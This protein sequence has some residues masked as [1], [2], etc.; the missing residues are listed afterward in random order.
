MLLS[1][2]VLRLSSFGQ[3]AKGEASSRPRLTSLHK[4]LLIPGWG[5]ISEKRYIEGLLF[6]TAEAFCF[7]NVFTYDRKGNYYYQ[8]YKEAIIPS[9]VATY[10]ELTEKFDVKRNKYLAA[11]VAI[12]AFNLVDIYIIIKKKE[13]KRSNLAFHFDI[14]AEKEFSASVNFCF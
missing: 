6:L 7:Y 12:W 10:R 13:R 5:Q 11:A 2:S 1:F 4:S 14:S 3:E 9:D 8:K